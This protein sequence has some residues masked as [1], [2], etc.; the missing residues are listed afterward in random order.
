MRDVPLAALG[1]LRTGTSTDNNLYA[2]TRTTGEATWR[3]AR[4]DVTANIGLG[5]S[6]KL[7]TELEKY[8]ATLADCKVGGYR[9]FIKVY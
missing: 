7:R 6:A 3:R 4:E 5:T 1:L 2:I 8:F 9:G